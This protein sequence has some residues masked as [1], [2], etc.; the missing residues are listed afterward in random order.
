M[1]ISTEYLAND[2]RLGKHY[3]SQNDMSHVGFE[4]AY[5]ELTSTYSNV[6]FAVG[7]VTRQIKSA[8]AGR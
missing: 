8:R 4:L 6:N 7:T 2:D 1:H 5:L 3:Y